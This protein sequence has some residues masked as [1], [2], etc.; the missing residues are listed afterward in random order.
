MKKV[1]FIILILT[2]SLSNLSAQGKNWSDIYDFEITSVNDS[3][4]IESKFGS[5]TVYGENGDAVYH[6][7]YINGDSI[8]DMASGKVLDYYYRVKQI[9]LIGNDSTITQYETVFKWVYN[10][11]NN[12]PDTAYVSQIFFNSNDTGYSIKVEQ[13]DFQDGTSYMS[14]GGKELYV[15]EGETELSLPVMLKIKR[16]VINGNVKDDVKKPDEIVTYA[17]W[18]NKGFYRYSVTG[19]KDSLLFEGLVKREQA[20]KNFETVRFDNTSGEPFVFS[21]FYYNTE[22]HYY[23]STMDMFQFPYKS[24]AL[25]SNNGT[26]KSNIWEKMNLIVEYTKTLMKLKIIGKEFMINNQYELL[27]KK[28]SLLLKFSD[29]SDLRKSI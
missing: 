2:I 10:T 5:R 19:E 25:N 9:S 12:I 24:G 8:E 16:I 4:M 29:D 21:N 27:Q 22:P 13:V 15:A 14:W 20:I 23:V 6:S 28:F 7:M 17:E 1:T 18:T 11:S 26:M 3:T